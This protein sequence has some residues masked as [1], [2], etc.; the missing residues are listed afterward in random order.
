M[1]LSIFNKILG[2]VFDRYPTPEW[3]FVLITLVLIFFM[4]WFVLILFH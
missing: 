1:S 2:K 4:G 3:V